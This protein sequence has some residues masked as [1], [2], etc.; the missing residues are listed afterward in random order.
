MTS[1]SSEFQ[2]R[3]C[4]DLQV[5]IANGATV[6]SSANLNGTFLVGVQIPTGFVGSSL[7]FQGSNDNNNFFVIKSG[8]TGF[9]LE[10]IAGANAI[11]NIPTSDL[12]TVQ[13]LKL[14]ATTAQTSDITIKLITRS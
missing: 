3:L 12:T 6:S 2:N 5:V 11:Y 1:I 9:D 7:K 4:N 8:I 13:Y 10:T 14:V